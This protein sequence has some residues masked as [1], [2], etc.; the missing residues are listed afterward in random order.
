MKH[1]IKKLRKR[2]RHSVCCISLIYSEQ[3][4]G[5]QTTEAEFSIIKTKRNKKLFRTLD[6]G[7][8]KEQQN[9]HKISFVTF[10][11]FSPPHLDRT[12]LTIRDN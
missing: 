3:I 5:L 12:K 11:Q 9:W 7:K 1:K 4:G 6:Y 8:E 2:V 10:N